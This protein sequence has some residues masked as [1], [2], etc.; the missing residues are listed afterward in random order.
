MALD[1]DVNIY[2][3][4]DLIWALATRVDPRKDIMIIAQGGMGQ[5]F[6]PADR[7]S[8]GDR[9]WIQ[10]N[11]EFSGSIGIDATVPYQFRDASSGPAIR[12]I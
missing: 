3:A 1:Q 4:D 8:A 5:V 7:S 11:I 10:S 12:L 2:S 6:Q 9:D